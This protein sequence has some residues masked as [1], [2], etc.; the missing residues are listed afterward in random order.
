MDRVDVLLRAEL[1]DDRRTLTEVWYDHYR[2]GE[3]VERL[4]LR[5][6]HADA[7]WKRWETVVFETASRAQLS[8]F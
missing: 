3:R 8:L 2:N 6:E 7:A 1:V 5:Q 4:Q